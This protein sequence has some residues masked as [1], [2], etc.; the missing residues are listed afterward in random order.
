MQQ[1]SLTKEQRAEAL[2]R[3]WAA[4]PYGDHG[5]R[6]RAICSF[7]QEYGPLTE[8][9]R[10]AAL[11]RWSPALREK[12]GIS[13]GFWA[14]TDIGEK[15]AQ[16]LCG[17]LLDD[18][19]YDPDLLLD[20]TG[21]IETATAEP[22]DY[23]PEPLCILLKNRIP[24]DL[25]HA[26]RPI[27]RKAATQRPIAGGNRG[28]AAGTGMVQRRRRD[29]TMSKIKGAQ[30]LEDLSD[31][32]FPRLRSATDGLVGFYD[33]SLRPGGQVY[34]CRI[35]H[36]DGMLP[37]EFRLVSELAKAVAEVF[38]ESL[39]KDRWE[40]QLKKAKQTPP[41]WLIRSKEGITPFT[42][43]TCNKSWRTAAHMDIGDLK[44]GFGVMCCLGD[45][46]GCD[47]VFPRYRAA[48]RYR[49]G[50]VLLANVHQ[51]HGNT[52]LLNPDDTVPRVG[53][54]PERLVCVF[55]Y[56]EKMDQCERTIEKEHEFINRRERGEAIRKPKAKAKAAGK[57]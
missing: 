27:V 31:E 56:R 38:K 32:H 20:Q 12:L 26:V 13:K 14:P 33:R 6:M 46:E 28:A 35:T 5:Q 41:I 50:D 44:Q 15:E 52:P 36:Y 23:T 25:L 8:D 42:T 57:K 34:P 9:E 53:R 30:R 16:K 10:R 1:Q 22:P 43:I 54:E 4:F 24:Q 19:H 39:V 55:Y 29:G 17:Q 18:S 21:V 48:V 40:A 51:V 11:F 2:Q 7:E 49:E 3:W 37:R 47:L 45:F